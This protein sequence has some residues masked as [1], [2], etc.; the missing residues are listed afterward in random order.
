MHCH[1]FK[2]NIKFSRASKLSNSVPWWCN[3]YL[4]YGWIIFLD[5][6][7]IFIC[8]SMFCG[9]RWG[10]HLNVLRELAEGL[11]M[12]LSIFDQKSWLSREV[13]EVTGGWQMW[14]PATRRAG[15]TQGTSGL[16]LDLSTREGHGVDHLKC[17]HTARTAKPGDHSWPPRI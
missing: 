16:Q 2:G 12:P 14:H 17:N 5:L 9:A 7:I 11:T 10:I 8:S 13:P 3:S 4:T 6:S 1:R 15:S